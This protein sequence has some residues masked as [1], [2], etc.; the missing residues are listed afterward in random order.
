MSITALGLVAVDL[1]VSKEWVVLGFYILG[2]GL[3]T[4]IGMTVNY[5]KRTA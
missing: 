1:I 3:G 2:T 5:K 4:F